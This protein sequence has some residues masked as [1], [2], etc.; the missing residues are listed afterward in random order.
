MNGGEQSFDEQLFTEILI[1]N[2]G[3][4]NGLTKS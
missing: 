2:T 4:V 1:Q 3:F